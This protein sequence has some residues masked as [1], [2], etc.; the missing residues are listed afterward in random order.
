[1]PGFVAAAM[2][3][4]AVFVVGCSG[5]QQTFDPLAPSSTIAFQ[6]ALM[7]GEAVA[8]SRTIRLSW[9]LPDASVDFIVIE[10]SRETRDGPW[11]EIATVRP[12]RG[13][14][15]ESSI[16]RPGRAYYFRAFVV[17]G[18]EEAIPTDPLRVWVPYEPRRPT[19]TPLPAYT[20]TPSPTP[21]P[22][23]GT[24]QPDAT[25]EAVSS[26]APIL[27]PTPTPPSE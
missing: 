21:D 4:T 23:G 27:T 8:G 1:V 10:E 18:N 20:P 13:F 24:P 11:E 6:A 9:T 16:Y 3:I 14:H 15:Q 22:E 26:A 12:L 17:R 19:N 2:A 7:P 5:I 25:A